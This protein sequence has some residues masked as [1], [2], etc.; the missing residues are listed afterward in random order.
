MF[1]R[2]HQIRL[3]LKS[4]LGL[5]AFSISLMVPISSPAQSAAPAT[6]FGSNLKLASADS[7]APAAPGEST[8]SAATAPSTVITEPIDASKL[9]PS[10]YSGWSNSL[11]PIPGE[12]NYIPIAD[13]YRIGFPYWSRYPAGTPGEYPYQTGAWY[14]PYNQNVLK[15]D[16]PIIGDHTFLILDGLSDSV[17]DFRRIP[18]PSHLATP[19]PN[20]KRAFVGGNQTAYQQNFVT[21]FDL[22]H[23]D[24]VFKPA[25]W[26]FKFTPVFNMHYFDSSKTEAFNPPDLA[27]TNHHFTQ[28]DGHVAIQEMFG[29]FKLADVSSFYDTINVRVGIQGF[30]SDFRGFVFVDNDPGIRFFGSFDENKWQWNLAYFWMLDKDTFTGLNTIFASQDVNIVTA[31][32]T[33][34]DFIWPGYFSQL[35][36]LFVNSNPDHQ[37]DDNGNEVRPAAV[38]KIRDH[39]INVGYYGITGDGHIGPINIDHAFYEAYGHDTFNNIAEKAQTVNAQMGAL[40]LSKDEDWIRYRVSFLYFSGDSNPHDRQATGW[41]AP[42]D[43]ENFA[44]DGFSFWGREGVPFPNTGINFKNRFSL[45][46]SFKGSNQPGQ[47]QPNYVNP[48]LFLYNAAMDLKL[49]PKLTITPNVNYVSVANT[50]VIHNLLAIGNQ[51]QALGSNMG[52]DWGVGFKYRPFLIDNVQI[53]GGAAAFSPFGG[54]RKIYGGQTLL[55]CFTAVDFIF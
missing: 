23:G 37:L 6:E 54:W 24:T 44:G 18:L 30:T 8:P 11:S 14:N 29:Q 7:T 45:I 38:G 17:Y 9:A 39:T 40:E 27:N 3:S 53:A 22:I 32:L 21:A 2:A 28:R 1:V 41:D 50:S 15:G 5:L 49:T 34:Q 31:N 20:V 10:G 35:D 33:R 19:P 42:L 52:L 26:E 25:D 48:G 36:F 13:R 46:P 4:I 55:M 12:D 43:N 47:A 51:N 16:Y